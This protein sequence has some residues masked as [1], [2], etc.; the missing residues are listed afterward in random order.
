MS[1]PCLVGTRKQVWEGECQKTSYGKRGLRKSDLMLNKHGKIV[2]VR[3]HAHGK[4]MYLQ[5]KGDMKSQKV[6]KP[7]VLPKTPTSK[8]KP[9]T[10]EELNETKA[11][12]PN[13]MRL[14]P[15]SVTIKA[16]SPFVQSIVEKAKKMRSKRKKGSAAKYKFD[17]KLSQE[18]R[19][20]FEATFDEETL[21]S[22]LGFSY[23]A[24]QE[25]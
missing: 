25:A 13:D 16:D 21:L 24:W 1:K 14:A 7:E 19:E 20:A 22:Q 11:K 4:Q 5:N 8:Q 18:K 6:Q 10:A 3:A 2:S 17:K 23:P 9:L 15:K 12:S